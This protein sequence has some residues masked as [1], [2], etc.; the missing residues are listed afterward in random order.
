MFLDLLQQP[1]H[2][3]NYFNSLRWR[4]RPRLCLSAKSA[5]TKNPKIFEYWFCQ[6]LIDKIRNVFIKQLHDGASV[7]AC[8]SQLKVQSKN[9]KNF[10]HWFCQWVTGKISK[11]FIKQHQ[12]GR[13]RYHWRPPRPSHGRIPAL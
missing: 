4:K 12:R 8:A 6:L 1:I 3:I 9:S 13:W 2:H 10:E 7:L 11:C 5:V